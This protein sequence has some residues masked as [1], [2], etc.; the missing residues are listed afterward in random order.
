MTL[1]QYILF[2]IVLVVGW[3]NY[4]IFMVGEVSIKHSKWGVDKKGNLK[5]KFRLI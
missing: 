3:I 5:K 2:D 1:Y 4:L